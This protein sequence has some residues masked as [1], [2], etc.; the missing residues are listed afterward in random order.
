MFIMP[1]YP[2]TDY[3]TAAAIGV[4]SGFAATGIHQIGKQLSGGTGVNSGP[5]E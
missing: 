5:G 4:V 2:A 1:D 3:M